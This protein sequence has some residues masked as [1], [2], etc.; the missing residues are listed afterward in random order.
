MVNE[1]ILFQNLNEARE[2]RWVDRHDVS[3]TAL[4]VLTV[5]DTANGGVIF[6]VAVAR[7]NANGAKDIFARWF[8]DR[9]ATKHYV[10]ND[11]GIWKVVGVGAEEKELKQLEMLC[12][13]YITNLADCE[14]RTWGGVIGIVK[15]VEWVVFGLGDGIAEH[16][17]FEFFG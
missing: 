8:Q 3:S 14:D 13:D 16:C 11:L 12:E 5:F 17:L 9:G 4:H 10:G 6:G 2:G 1:G 7:V 15:H